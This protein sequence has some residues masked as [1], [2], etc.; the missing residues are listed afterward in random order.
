MIQKILYTISF[1][2]ILTRSFS[3]S[4][5]IFK[6]DF[7]ADDP[8][9]TSYNQDN[10]VTETRE[11]RFLI[12]HLKDESSWYQYRECYVNPNEDYEIILSE[13]QYRGENNQGFG[14]VFGAKDL[15]NCYV[16]DISS[17]GYFAVFKN[18]DEK[19]T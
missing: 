3:Q 11:G 10:V 12:Q 13:K 16:F 1:L 17:S 6:C 2:F 9:W 14:L 5:Y 15:D 4:D 18:V 8:E 7:N 19:Y